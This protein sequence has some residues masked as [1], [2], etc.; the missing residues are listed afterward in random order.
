MAQPD[1]VVSDVGTGDGAATAEATPA[2]GAART[3]EFKPVGAQCN[4]QYFTGYRPYQERL[5][6]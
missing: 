3:V 2:G 6:S 5:Y 4:V 1:R